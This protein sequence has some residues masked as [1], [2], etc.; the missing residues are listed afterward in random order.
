MHD[1]RCYLH[2]GKVTSE[3]ARK[4]QVTVERRASL[5]VGQRAS[6]RRE[7]QIP[8]FPRPPCRG[9]EECG[10]SGEVSPA[11]SCPTASIR[12]D[13]PSRCPVREWLT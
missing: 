6:G 2:Y 5:A 9:G 11:E 10:S 1:K 8:I 13:G 12:T 4:L 3:T 7:L